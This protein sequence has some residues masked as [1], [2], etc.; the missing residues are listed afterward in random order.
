MTHSP[1]PTRKSSP[2]RSA[3]STHKS[4]L[5]PRTKR[6]I[7]REAAA[8]GIPPQKYLTLVLTVSE[9]LR[10]SLGTNQKLDLS[11][12]TKWMDSPLWPVMVEWIA[13]TAGSMMQ[14]SGSDPSEDSEQEASGPNSGNAAAQPS[15]PPNGLNP[16]PGQMYPP[17]YGYPAPYN[18]YAVPPYSVPQQR[19]PAVPPLPMNTYFSPW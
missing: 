12:F 16:A 4:W 10:N 5:S 1:L 3:Q 14:L 2:S 19:R 17:G 18:P 13:K 8:L 11:G 6:R 7:A 9:S 15:K